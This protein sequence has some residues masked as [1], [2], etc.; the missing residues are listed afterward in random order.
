MSIGDR[1]STLGSSRGDSDGRSECRDSDDREA[2]GK[3][4]Q[5]SI[6]HS[7]ETL[8]MGDVWSWLSILFGVQSLGNIDEIARKASFAGPNEGALADHIG[9][10]ARCRR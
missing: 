4:E 1:A 10:V 3:P 2:A 9:E 7:Q 5:G 6:G 8:L